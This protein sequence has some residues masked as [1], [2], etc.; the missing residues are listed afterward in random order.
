MT[1]TNIMLGG[2]AGQGI[3]TIGQALAKAL[4]KS[5]YYLHVSQTYESR[6]RGGSNTFE[7]RAGSAAFNAPLEKVDILFA[8]NREIVDLY[9]PQLTEDAIIITDD[10]L[11]KRAERHLRLPV[12]QLKARINTVMLASAGALL[13]LDEQMLGDILLAQLGDADDKYEN[14]RG[15]SETYAWVSGQGLKIKA[16]GRPPLP[17]NHNLT[18]N[19][20]EA[21]ALGA[22]AGGLKFLSFYPMSPA[23]AISLSIADAA[24]ELGIVMEQAEDEIA[25]INM[26]IGASYAG[27]RAMV[28]TSGGG[29]ALMCEGVS[30]AGMIETPMVIMLAMRP[31][32]ATGLPTRSE[33]ADLNLTLYAG[34]GEFPRIILAPGDLEQSFELARLAF[35]L[36]EKYQAPVFVLTDQ[37]LSD[38]YRNVAPFTLNQVPALED[39]I[40]RP[41]D[42]YERYA[43]TASGVSPRVLPGL[44]SQIAISDSDEHTPS[45]HI[46]EDLPL[47]ARMQQKRMA[48]LN[49][50]RAQAHAPT[51]SGSANPQI[52]LCCWG[53]TL[54]AVEEAAA[55]LSG[56]GRQIGICHFQQLY[57]LNPENFMPALTEAQKVI[58][59]ESN[60]SGQ[61][62]DLLLRETG[63]KV[64]GRLLRYDG[65]AMTANYIINK[66]S[67][68]EG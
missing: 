14:R 48:K 27:A 61:M 13:G 46:T 24:P 47:R 19:G 16:L 3:A 64:H 45:G 67:A 52:M 38:S 18:L 12:A 55:I 62:A 54:G 2:Q 44:S 63:F 50:M 40:A 17:L 41:G 42:A 26:A 30:L 4:V 6:I 34:H 58:M 60:F 31:G 15:I 11:P 22:L 28:A 21:L 43:I 23:T 35:A 33:Q 57:P 8:M 7:L 59:V 20:S 39:A 49:G 32:P 25:A 53:S 5:G 51:I 29:F 10:S 68:M 56:Q 66:L 1:S 36:A 9:I 65:L 37:Y